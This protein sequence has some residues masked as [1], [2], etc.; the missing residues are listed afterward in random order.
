VTR[1][2]VVEDELAL[3]DALAYTLRQE[4]F[5]VELREDGESGR[6]CAGATWIARA[7]PARSGGSAASS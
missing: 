3:R 4:G 7:S 1:I 5:D 6:S 2:L